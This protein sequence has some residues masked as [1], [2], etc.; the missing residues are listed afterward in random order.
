MTCAQYI[1][2]LETRTTQILTLEQQQEIQQKELHQVFSP[3]NIFKSECSKQIETRLGKNYDA[4][5]GKTH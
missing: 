2:D 5:E 4:A 1:K 3:R